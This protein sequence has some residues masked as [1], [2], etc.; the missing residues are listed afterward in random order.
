MHQLTIDHDSK[1]VSITDHPDFGDAHRALLQYVVGADYYLRRVQNAAAHT[2]YEL[3][4]VADLDDPTP[5]RDP[6]VT[7]IAT[8]EEVPAAELPVSAPY[9]T[10]CDAQRWISDHAAMWLYGSATDPG[11]SYPMAVLT[12]AHGEARC[13]LRA[14]TLLPEAADLAG[15]QGVAHPD[16]AP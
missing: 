7:G 6:H 9:F 8:I 15:V 13:Y 10:A 11:Y 12:V 1:S 2:S 4:R 14:G 5:A 3:L 16:Q